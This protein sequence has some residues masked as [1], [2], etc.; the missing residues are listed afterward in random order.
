MALESQVK[1]ID[2]DTR[3]AK[4]EPVPE[5]EIANEQRR[6]EEYEARKRALEEDLRR[7]TALLPASPEILGVARVV[8]LRETDPVMRSDAEIEAIGMRVA[9]DY[10]RRQG[11][12]PEDV[13]A[14]NLGYDIRS[15]EPGGLVR[16]I[17]VKARVTTGAIALTPNEWLMAQRLGEQYWL[18]VVENAA[19]R[20]ALYTLQNPAAT[21][22]PQEVVEIVRFIVT[23]WKEWAIRE[24]T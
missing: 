15:T 10:E 19:R 1:L 14:Q 22:K 11:R 4:G 5:A 24:G 23:D 16:Y 18:Y 13:S 2:Y 20:P 6:K 21:L 12:T 17:E 3:R 8:P 7:Q 9:M